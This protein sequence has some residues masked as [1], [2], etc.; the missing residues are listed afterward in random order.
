MG[1]LTSKDSERRRLQVAYYKWEFLRRNESYVKDYND[2][3]CSYGKALK[4]AKYPEYGWYSRLHSTL[5]ARLGEL[6]FKWGVSFMQ[7]PEVPLTS[8]F[9]DPKRMGGNPFCGEAGVIVSDTELIDQ[10]S[11]DV[12]RFIAPDIDLRRDWEW[13]P[14]AV[15]LSARPDTICR[16]L[17]ALIK[18]AKKSATA[19]RRL[20]CAEKPQ[21]I[22]TCSNSDKWM[23]LAAKH[24]TSSES[25][26]SIRLDAKAF[27]QYLMA[28]EMQKSG[29]TYIDIAEALNEMK[30]RTPQESS[31][32]IAH[33]C[34]RMA[35]KFIKGNYRLI[36]T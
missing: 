27:D 25:R 5:A 12:V 36:Y 10:D 22:T 7:S 29:K 32:D 31:S 20:K 2:L 21:Y 24:P 8:P 1:R 33:Q 6:H 3:F 30:K 28:W 19:G 23:Q 13:L 15:N 34:V 14:V 35:R 9:F 11:Y 26:N 18:K 4:K 17:V 16:E